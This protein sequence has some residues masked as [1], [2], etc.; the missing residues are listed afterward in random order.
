MI[1]I[2][3]TG[4]KG[5]T[6]TVKLLEHI[7][8]NSGFRTYA[9]YGLAGIHFHSF[10][11]GR[12]I[13]KETIRGKKVKVDVYEWNYENNPVDIQVTEATSHRLN[14]GSYKGYTFNIAIFTSFEE[15]EHAHLHGS[16][17]KYFI[18]KKKIFSLLSE[19]QQSDFRQESK[20]IVCR[21]I[22]NFS[23]IISGCHCPVI[24]YGFHKDSDY[25]VEIKEI[26]ENLMN[27][28]IHN[29]E[30]AYSFSTPLRGDVNA[31]NVAAAF[32]VTKILSI[33]EQQVAVSVNRFK[34]IPGRMET[35]EIENKN[36]TV[37]IDYAHTE[38]SLE[39]LLKLAKEAYPDKKLKCLFGCGGDRSKDKRKYMG[40]AAAK[41]A[42]S[43]ILTNDNPRKEN[44]VNI[45][46][47]IEE[48]IKDFKY[49]TKIPDRKEA[50][51]TVLSN[52]SDSIIVLA[53]K[54]DERDIQFKYTKVCHRDLDEVK[55][56]C[57]SNSIRLKKAY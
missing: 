49:L 6:T 9:L 1:R 22:K 45:L 36:N 35:Y 4:T 37:I 16:Q 56:W 41:Y 2:G 24:T 8:L 28:E 25:R 10:Y 38:E 47:D 39:S 43:I 27:F 18:S 34:N 5:K 48:N 7:F 54:G 14:V 57:L 13:L 29:D 40:M 3:V 53:G 15:D 11:N 42:D 30:N 23:D 32:V 19:K 51:K 21:D 33:P 46:L 52:S 50:I 55:E 20:A 31:K 44:P 26:K 12:R 17:E